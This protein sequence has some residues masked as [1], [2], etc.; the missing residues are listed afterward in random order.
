MINKN[1]QAAQNNLA[2]V[3]SPFTSQ[4]AKQQQP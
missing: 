4:Y 3:K 2:P 1:I